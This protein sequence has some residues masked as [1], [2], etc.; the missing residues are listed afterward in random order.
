MKKVFKLFFLLI[1]LI[2]L[3]LLLKNPFSERNLI[4]NLEPFPDT[5]HYL[6]P[7]LSLLRGEGLYVVREGRVLVT[8]VPP[9]Y[10]LTLIPIYLLNQDVRMFYFINL[11]LAIVSFLAFYKTLEVLIKNNWI[12]LVILFL[13]VT[14]YFVYWYPNL[15][16]AENLILTLFMV[17]LFLLVRKSNSLSIAAAGFLAVSFYATKYAAVTLSLA[18][19]LMYLAKILTEYKKH[20]LKKTCLLLAATLTAFLA[21]A[22]FEYFVKGKNSF[23]SI[24]I[25]QS[26]LFPTQSPVAADLVNKKDTWFSFIYFHKNIALYINALIGNPMK[27]LWDMTPLTPK[28]VAIAGIFGLFINLVKKDLRIVITYLI[29]SIAF[30]V[31]FLSTFYSVDARYIYHAIPALLI[32]FGLFLTL[33]S[34]ISFFKKRKFIFYLV[35]LSV[36][37]IYFGQNAIRLKSQIMIN[38]KYAETPWYYIAAKETNIFFDAIEPGS[39]KPVLISA[40]PPYYLD[41]FS[42]GKYSLLPL[43]K[44]Q[45]FRSFKEIAWGP[46]DYSDLIALYNKYLKSG[47]DMYVSNNGLGNEGY[48]HAGFDAINENFNLTKVKSACFDTCNIY[49][50]SP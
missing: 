38:I 33:L 27:F 6:N 36:F 17:S 15:A 28:Y 5:I 35:L 4:S 41:F 45:E 26:W 24:L 19:I 34:E 18:F 13:Y 11:V 25:L 7:S 39:K 8:A 42:R 9:L 10:S 37:V 1:F 20:S 50:I 21:F 2:F 31:L 48:L 12:I 14:N 3:L 46:N 30:T 47:Y 32:G 29:L 22:L 44:D 23:S 40:L 43:S 49:K 16:M